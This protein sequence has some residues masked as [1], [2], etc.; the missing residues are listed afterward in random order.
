[1]VLEGGTLRD[2][3][4]GARARGTTLEVRTLFYNTPARRKFLKSGQT[5]LS[6][7]T[8]TVTEIA[9]A[10]PGIHFTLQ[11]AG[12]ALVKA[13]AVDSMV[14][15]ASQIFGKEVRQNLMEVAVGQEGLHLFGFVSVPGFTRP[16]GTHINFFVN[17]RAVRD[18]TL[19]HAVYAAYETLLMKGRHPMVY[20]FLDVDPAQ[21][22]VNV[23][24][25]KREVRFTDPRRI[26]DFVR[27]AVRMSVQGYGRETPAEPLA[28]EERAESGPREERVREAVESYLRGQARETRSRPTPSRPI[29]AAGVI[30]PVGQGARAPVGALFEERLVPLG[31]LADTFIISQDPEGLILVDQHA[32]HERILFERF[33]RHFDE[34]RVPV[35]RL[36]VP[37][38]LEASAKEAILLK[39]H[40]DLFDRLGV[41]IEDFG[42][43]S[44]VIKGVPVWVADADI[45]DLIR[46]TLGEIE[47][48]ER[49]GTLRQQMDDVIHLFACRGAVKANRR[50]TTEEMEKLLAELGR[51]DSPHTCEHGRPTMIRIDRQDIEKMF[52]RR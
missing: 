25:A 41:E 48:L 35:Q 26:H 15:R 40:A 14:E 9:L 17:R 34:A 32:A 19:R 10:H 36:L 46:A 23:H 11:H 28:R 24:P 2:V 30:R 6:H 22:D 39:E 7:I 38:T 37:I 18:K 27:D 21:V 13:P 5:E 29:T 8:G 47:S 4:A 3:R 45:T 16:N 33:R 31:Q 20:L 1:M 49:A 42:N 50:L 51:T 52:R 12:R 43:R 44:F